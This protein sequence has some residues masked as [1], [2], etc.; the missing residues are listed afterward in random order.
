MNFGWNEDQVALRSA[1]AEFGAR[2]LT[3]G[4]VDRDRNSTFS[5]ELWSACADFGL[6]GLIIPEAW[7]G[8]GHDMLT[9]VAILEGVGLG[10]LDNGMVFSTVAHAASVAGPIVDYGTEEQQAQ[11]LPRLA[12]G[13]VIG[14]AAITE[15]GTGSNSLGMTTAA[16]QESEHWVLDGSK[17][18][19]S[20]APIAD[21]FLVYARTGKGSMA[22]LSCFL[23]PAETKGLSV[24]KPIEK[25]GLR[26]S[27]MAEVFFDGCRVPGSALLGSVGSGSMIFNLT[28]DVERLLVMA[29]AIGVM[30]RLLDRCVAHA[31][32]RNIGSGP[33]GAHQAVSHPIAD[34]ELDLETSRL[35]LY[36]AAWRTENH[37]TITRESALAKLAVSEAYIRCC[38]TAMQVF[39]G[40]GYT[41]EYGLEREL[42][43]A[44]ATT[45]YVGTSEIQR[46]LIAGLRGIR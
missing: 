41:V 32:E 34:M 37:G 7:S 21:L 19:I 28:M 30:E 23:V 6:T 31:R 9:A 18:F 44:L 5:P 4:I 45:L 42:R 17:T 22:G 11:W 12:D 20:N 13:S 35:A 14:A 2:V 1:A 39:G 15:P 27:P 25:M 24:G 3:E 33:I 10:A 36:R 43:D 46:N 8:L 40:Y 16:R 38:R 29:P 26:T